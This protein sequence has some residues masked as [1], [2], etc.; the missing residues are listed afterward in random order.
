M[1]FHIIVTVVILVSMVGVLF[2]ANAENMIHEST[3][4]APSIQTP[5]YD[6]KNDFPIN[7]VVS[8]ANDERGTGARRIDIQ[9]KKSAVHGHNHYE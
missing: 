1:Y 9:L 5:T 6:F 4:T 2:D 3:I 8:P 7:D